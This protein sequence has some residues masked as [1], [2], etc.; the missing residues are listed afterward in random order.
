M[1]KPMFVSI[2]LCFILV[3]IKCQ[4]IGD[5]FLSHSYSIQS[6]NAFDFSKKNTEDPNILIINNDFINISTIRDFELNESRV[7]YTY[8]NDTLVFESNGQK[9]IE[10]VANLN[11]DTLSLIDY[12]K[13][14]TYVVLRK[15][16]K[17]KNAPNSDKFHNYL[18]DNTFLVDFTSMIAMKRKNTNQTTQPDTVQF[19]SNNSIYV[20]LEEQGNW[21]LFSI[22]NDLYIL[23]EQFLFQIVKSDKKKLTLNSYYFDSKHTFEWEI[24]K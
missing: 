9:Q 2:L 7:F 5:W 1:N 23:M 8:S 6:E 11:A 3:Q 16:E 19:L 20:N 17:V 15:I 14:G 12:D 4:L 22:H 24:I 18:V 21:R 10:F 13:K